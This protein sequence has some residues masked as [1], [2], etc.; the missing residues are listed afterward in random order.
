[1]RYNFR[2]TV[3]TLLL[4][5]LILSPSLMDAKSKLSLKDRQA[6]DI[7]KRDIREGRATRSA[8]SQTVVMFVTTV[9]STHPEDIVVPGVTVIDHIG[10]AFIVELSMETVDIFLKNDHIKAA[11]FDHC[12][13][14]DMFYA[15]M[16]GNAN[17]NNA[18]T[19]PKGELGHSYMGKDVICGVFMSIFSIMK[20]VVRQE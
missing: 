19:D 17:I 16:E 11:S 7:M 2:H 3:T 12:D 1:M 9:P 15:R 6:I 18:H 13:S 10:D 20:T 8:A 5:G 4:S 14:P